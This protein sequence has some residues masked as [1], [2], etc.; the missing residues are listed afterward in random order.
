MASSLLYKVKE[1][2]DQLA[3]KASSLKPLLIG[4]KEKR[5][6]LSDNTIDIETG[7][8]FLRTGISG[9]QTFT[10]SNASNVEDDA[11][12]SFLLTVT[13]TGATSITWWANIKWN[14]GSVPQLTA[15]GRD[16]FGFVSYDKGATW[17]G[18]VMSK[19]AK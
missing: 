4:L 14:A 8:A 16:T 5:I 18:Y 3:G 19:D 13:T 9:A 15:N 11:V 1:L 7:N 17:D 12:I 10:V 2:Y 6:I